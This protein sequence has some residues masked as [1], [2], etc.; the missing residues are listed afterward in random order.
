K[1]ATALV[2]LMRVMGGSMMFSIIAVFMPD[3]WLEAAVKQVEHGVPVGPLVEYMARGWSAFYFML[4]GLIWMFSTDLSRYFAAIRWLSWCYILING[5]FLAV[6]LWLYASH[7]GW[8]W[9]FGA[10]TFNVTMAFLFGL[11]LLILSNKANEGAASQTS[12]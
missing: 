11:A 12:A 10:I 1:S 4:G 9:F 8:N 2:F 6:L 7:E 3:A 5:A